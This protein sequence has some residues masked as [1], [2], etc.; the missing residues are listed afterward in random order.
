MDNVE[1]RSIVE[2]EMEATAYDIEYITWLE[3]W[4]MSDA[5]AEYA[6][7]LVTNAKVSIELPEGM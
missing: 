1:I 6:Q 5:E 2:S 3:A 7:W 4:E